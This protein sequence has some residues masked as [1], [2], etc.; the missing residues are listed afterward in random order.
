MNKKLLTIAFSLS[1]L[2]ATLQAADTPAR[3][4][5]QGPPARDPATAGYVEAKELPDGDVPAADADG[6]FII[7]P[8]HKRAADMA[9]QE[10][11]PQGAI[12]EF[13]MK[14]ADSK[15]YPGISRQPNTF[16]TADPA[17]PAKL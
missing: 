7:G 9:K 15:I 1:T 16:G 13:T 3:P 17:N 2:A 12:R 5:R 4:A 11:V 8:T 10:G 14:S 6:N